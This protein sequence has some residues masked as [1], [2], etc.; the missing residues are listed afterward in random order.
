MESRMPGNLHVRFGKRRNETDRRKPTRRVAPT[1]PWL[2]EPATTAASMAIVRPQAIDDAPAGP[3]RSGGWRRRDFLGSRGMG[4]PGSPRAW[5]AGWQAQGKKVSPPPLRQG[6]RGAAVLWPDHAIKRPR[7][8]RARQPRKEKTWRTWSAQEARFNGRRNR[9]A[10]VQ[11]GG[12]S[13]PG[14]GTALAL[15]TPE[16]FGCGYRCRSIEAVARTTLF[17][18]SFDDRH[19][20]DTQ[21]KI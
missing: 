2:F 14:P 7:G 10:G 11:K 18:V 1:S 12:P 4:E 17:T 3:E 15:Q 5:G 6:D 21:P 8:S 19:P 13:Y 20:P 16:S 9:N